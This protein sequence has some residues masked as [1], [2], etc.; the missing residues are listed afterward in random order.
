[1]WKRDCTREG[2]KERGGMRGCNRGMSRVRVQGRMIVRE[3]ERMR[4][5]E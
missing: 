3:G 4:R 5:R 1:M 2:E